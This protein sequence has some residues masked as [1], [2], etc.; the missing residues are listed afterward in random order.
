MNTSFKLA[1][2]EILKKLDEIEAL[3]E[4]RSSMS[5]KEQRV[6][7]EELRIGGLK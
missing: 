3:W 5:M 7:A 2:A 4:R 6:A 1:F